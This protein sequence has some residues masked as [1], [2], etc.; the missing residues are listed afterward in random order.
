MKSRIK[1]NCKQSYF[2]SKASSVNLCFIKSASLQNFSLMM[3]RQ[4]SDGISG[5]HPC[6]AL[7]MMI[8]EFCPKMAYF[9]LWVGMQI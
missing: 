4:C 7:G 1:P 3:Q 8:C 5:V 6:W 2:N 9:D